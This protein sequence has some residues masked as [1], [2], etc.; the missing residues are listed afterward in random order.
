MTSVRSVLFLD[1]D[2]VFRGLL[3]LDPDVAIRFAQDPLAWVNALADRDDQEP[4]RWLVLRCYIDPNGS[5]TH[6]LAPN[7]RV[8]FSA[9]LDPFIS[10][11]FEVIST[12]DPP[13]S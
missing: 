5:A 2:S 9:F 7:T 12:P 6:P 10:A 13:S 11:G 8:K 1:F 3:E 4:P